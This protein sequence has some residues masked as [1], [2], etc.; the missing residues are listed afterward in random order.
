VS[1]KELYERL[2]IASTDHLSWG[3]ERPGEGFTGGIA[4][5]G[6][7]AEQAWPTNT[8]CW[9]GLSVMDPAASAR[10]TA[11]DVIRIP[12]VWADLDVKQGG[13]TDEASAA[14]V[15]ATL[16]E[17]LNA[18]PAGIIFSGGGLQ[19]VWALECDDL[20]RAK[21]LLRRFGALVR[22]VADIEAHAAVDNVFEPARILRMPGTNNMKQDAP[23]PARIA[24]PQN[25]TPLE[26]DHL[27]DVC[28]AYGAQDRADP[29]SDEVR[30]EPNDWKYAKST[31]GY[32][33]TMWN[34]WSSDAPM[35]GRHNWLGA[36][37]VRLYSAKRMGCFTEE[38]FDKA[39]TTLVTRFAE[40][41]EQGVGGVKRK[42]D[43]REVASWNA[44]AVRRASTKSDD[45]AWRE[46]G[47]S[48]H[49]HWLPASLT[50]REEGGL[51]TEPDKFLTGQGLLVADLA[52]HVAEHV[53]PFALGPDGALWR[54]VEGVYRRGGDAVAATAVSIVMGNRYRNTHRDNVLAYLKQLT[55]VKLSGVPIAPEYINC[56]NGLLNWRTGDLEPHDPS[57]PSIIQIPVDW[58][59]AASAPHAKRFI[60]QSMGGPEMVEFFAEVAGAVVY[61]GSPKHQRAVMLEGGGQNGKS[62]AIALL[63]ALVGADNCA[64]VSPQRLDQRFAASQLYGKL[65]N[66]VGDVDAETFMHTATFKGLVSGDNIQAEEKFKK[67]F[68]FRPVATIVCS[69]NELPQTADRSDGFYRRWLVVPFPNKFVDNPSGD[70]QYSRD[71]GLINRL[72][73]PG[74][75]S[76]FLGM[77]VAGL[78]RLAAR[79]WQ[80]EEPMV[81]RR[82]NDE[83]RKASNPVLEW[84][85]YEVEHDPLGS[86]RVPTK[87]VYDAYHTYCLNNGYKPMASNRFGAALKS[88][89]VIVKKSG[90]NRY[91]EGLTLIHRGGA[92]VFDIRP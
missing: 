52:E 37:L 17:M 23:R 31:C 32:A 40:L 24:Y 22:I 62:V 7:I 16:S 33:N 27:Q 58:D 26:A 38:D 50:V 53:G 66:L 2:E 91:Y 61:G 46:L 86:N 13:F 87:H 49:S 21:V 65:A 72:T 20:E 92:T 67:P 64:T 47:G 59:P 55:K 39:L 48:P 75:L 84:F 18:G 8:N 71:S 78:Q 4:T 51:V 1:I 12:A 79:E 41:C 14:K 68:G 54:Y 60:E 42:A 9:A 10:G 90:P 15:I 70:R 77:A 73:Q 88:M 30:S 56:K 11:A 69:F 34:G 89:G 35:N 43:S 83:Y 5:A 82:A 28:D 44:W 74:E 25:W 3:T 80:F 36:Q 76:G 19:P 81:V 6:Q 45:S 63:E 85:E 57:F 29:Y